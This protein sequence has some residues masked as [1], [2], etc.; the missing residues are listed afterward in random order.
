MN[1][2]FKRKRASLGEKIPGFAGYDGE[3][4]L[5]TDL[6]LRRHLAAEMEKV[7][8]RL[9]DFAAGLPLEGAARE[10]LGQA[11]RMTAFLKEE[12]APHPPEGLGAA[13][14]APEEERLLDFDLALLEKVAGLHTPLDRM[15]AAGKREELLRALALYEE[16][17]AEVEELFEKR[18]EVLKD[19]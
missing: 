12:L 1:R 7:R 2:D 16:G 9:A 13:P 19:A 5:E 15:E 6:L 14:A 8:D 18:R 10:P 4:T 3:Q 11:L 17:L